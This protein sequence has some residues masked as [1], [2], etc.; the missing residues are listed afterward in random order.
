MNIDGA[1]VKEQGQVF[2]I[3]IVKQ[4]AMSNPSVAAE[5]RAAFQ[6]RIRDFAGIPL[7]LA[8]QDSSG[9]FEYQGR[10]DIVRFLASIDA[11]RI[12][13]RRYTVS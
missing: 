6:S 13:W 5:T 4:S 11:S 7:I 1:I 2:G 12:P 3:V 8:S 9:V 10:R